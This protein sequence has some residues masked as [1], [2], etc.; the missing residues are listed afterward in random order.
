[1]NRHT[2]WSLLI[3]GIAGLGLIFGLINWLAQPPSHI[4]DDSDIETVTAE[5]FSAD[6]LT[7]AVPATNI[8]AEYLPTFLDILRPVV[9]HE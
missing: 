6:G 2:L 8:P 1:M 4:L 7:T 9:R 3:F 5:V